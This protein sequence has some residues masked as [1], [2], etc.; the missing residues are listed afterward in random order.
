MYMSVTFNSEFSQKKE[1]KLQMSAHGLLLK[2][3]MPYGSRSSMQEACHILTTSLL[4]SSVVEHLTVVQKAI[5]STAVGRTIFFPSTVACVTDQII[6]F[7]CP[8]PNL[9]YIILHKFYFHA[10]FM[11]YM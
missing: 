3:Q 8:F 7:S 6:S 5:G 10:R 4:I 9:K 1:T 11:Y 2:G